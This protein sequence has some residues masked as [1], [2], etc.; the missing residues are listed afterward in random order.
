MIA[1]GRWNGAA[2]ICREG[3]W[4]QEL[5]LPIQHA[6]HLLQRHELWEEFEAASE[7]GKACFEFGRDI[8]DGKVEGCSVWE[9]R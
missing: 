7:A 4:L 2:E 9:L 8:I 3:R 1:P 5:P 6:P